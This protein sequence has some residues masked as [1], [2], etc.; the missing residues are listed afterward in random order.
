MV[1]EDDSR[2]T[3]EFDDHFVIQPAFP[4][5]DAGAF[6]EQR[7]GAACPEGFRY[8]SD[9]NPWWLTVDELR[10]MADKV[11]H[12]RSELSALRPSNH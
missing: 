9:S 5:W 10:A 1:P 11:Q 2:Q 12:E 4:W 7:P 6:R 8:A 3:V